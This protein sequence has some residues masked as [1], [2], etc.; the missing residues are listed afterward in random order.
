[1]CGR[2]SWF[3]M[4]EPVLYTNHQPRS[5]MSTWIDFTELRAKLKFEDVL[6][7]Y[8]ITVARRGNQHTGP[9]P[10]PDHGGERKPRQFSANLQRG[11]FQCFGCEAAGNILDF[12]VRM[13]GRDPDNGADV[14]RVALTLHRKFCGG[15]AKNRPESK[16]KARPTSRVD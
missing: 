13:E 9:C 16:P 15:T 6:V 3:N 4:M 7:H 2:R 5:V 12:A 14:R 8:G 11:L 1:M 10:L